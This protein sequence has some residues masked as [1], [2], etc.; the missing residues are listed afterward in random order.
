MKRAAA[1]AL[2]ALIPDNETNETH[3]LPDV[4]DPRV[5]DAVAAAVKTA[6]IK[7]GAARNKVR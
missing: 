4:F 1:E 5:V 2:A 6:A 7:T 3:I